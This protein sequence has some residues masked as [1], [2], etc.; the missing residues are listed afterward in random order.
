MRIE[1]LE[2]ADYVAEQ[3]AKGGEEQFK[4]NVRDD[5]ERRR[6]LNCPTPESPAVEAPPAASAG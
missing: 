1:N 3:M 2:I 6:D 4:R 5:L